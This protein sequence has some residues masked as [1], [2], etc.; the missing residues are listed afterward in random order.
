M[1]KKIVRKKS[2]RTASKAKKETRN[3]FN[4]ETL[5]PPRGSRQRKVRVSAAASAPS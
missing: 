4:L 2:N 1:A 5:R 3:R